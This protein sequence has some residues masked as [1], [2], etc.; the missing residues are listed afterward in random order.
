MASTRQKKFARQ[1]QRDL[2][3]I[4]QREAPALFGG[5]FITVTQVQMSPD[6]RIAK[7]YLSF[8]LVNDPEDLLFAIEEK[9][10]HLRNVLGRR[11]KNQV[12]SVPELHFFIDDTAEVAAEVDALFDKIDIPPAEEGEEDDAADHQKPRHKA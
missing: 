1:I 12:R 6:L 2:G 4:F 11:L 7:V 8:L 10:S 9:N 5:A 3:E